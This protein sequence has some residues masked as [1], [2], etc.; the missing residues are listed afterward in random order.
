MR[1]LISTP[2]FDGVVPIQYLLGFQDTIAYLNAAKI[3]WAVYY[4]A[5]NLVSMARNRAAEYTLKNG[6][7]KLLF[8]DAD[9]SWKGIDVMRLLASDKKIVGGTYPFKNWPI[10]LNFIPIYNPEMPAEFDIQK[11]FID[12]YPDKETGEVEVYRLPTG[13]LLIDSQVFRDLGPHVPMYRHGDA[14]TGQIEA[15]HMFFPVEIGEDKV[16]HTED[17]GF[18]RAAQKIGHNIYWNT[19]VIVDHVGRHTYSAI[20]PKEKS[21]NKINVNEVD[22]KNEPVPNPFNQWPNNLSCYCGSGKKFK[23]CHRA[24]MPKHISKADHPALDESFK[25]QLAHV[26]AIAEGGNIYKLAQPVL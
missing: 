15:E 19:K 24:D 7:D 20:I 14:L 26:Q 4:E 25:K 3:E 16:L 23:R 10:K 9:I 17:W 2:I 8:I 5:R 1:L 18:C 11:D 6:F 13:F 21:Y 12:V 22:P